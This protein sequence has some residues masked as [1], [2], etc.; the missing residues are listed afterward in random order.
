MNLSYT[1]CISW[2]LFSVDLSSHNNSEC[3][4]LDLSKCLELNDLIAKFLIGL[5]SSTKHKSLK[6]LFF[7]YLHCDMTPERRKCAVRETPQRC[8]ML[9]NGSLDTCPQK[10][11]GLWNPE[12]CYE[13]NTRFCVH[14]ESR[15]ST[16]YGMS[17]RVNGGATNVLHGY[18]SLYQR[19]CREERRDSSSV[20]RPS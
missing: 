7:S 3:F 1:R 13:I 8:P 14:V 10:R 19:P 2:L 9:D 20:I 4:I 5:L 18:R 17:F 12:R 15:K 16:W 11:I 6:Y